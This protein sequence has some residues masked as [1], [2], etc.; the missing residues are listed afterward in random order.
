MTTMAENIKTCEICPILASRNNGQDVLVTETLHWRAVLDGDQR[1]LGKM[2]VTL[3]EHKPAISDLTAEEWQDLH[4]LMKS[5]ERAVGAAFSP[6]HFNWSCLM[7]NAVVAD[8]LTH[9]HWHLHPRYMEPIQFA[10]ETFYDTELYPPKERTRHLVTPETL[11]AIASS[12]Q[13]YLK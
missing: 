6:S 4:Q 10:D 7:N 9:I 13:S 5:L 12:I 8:Q 1:F 3:L 2:F 11:Q